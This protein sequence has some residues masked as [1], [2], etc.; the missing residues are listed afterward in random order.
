MTPEEARVAQIEVDCSGTPALSNRL[1]GGPGFVLA[2]ARIRR[3][4]VKIKAIEKHDLIADGLLGSAGVGAK[5][6]LHLRQRPQSGIKS[7]FSVALI[8]TASHLISASDSA[9][10][11]D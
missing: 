1:F 11:G 8:C 10:Q 2:L 3:R 6:I 9:N 5:L 4:V 7:S